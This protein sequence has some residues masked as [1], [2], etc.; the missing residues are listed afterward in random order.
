M[1]AIVILTNAPDRDSAERI[2]RALVESRAAACVNVLSPCTSVYRWQSAIQNDQEY[3]LLI[4][5]LREHYGRAEAVIRAH[6]PAQLPEIIAL[7]LSTGLPDYLAWI[8]H[9]TAQS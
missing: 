1:E 6:H 3:P 7:P 2:A 4:K 9:E 5:T 8:G